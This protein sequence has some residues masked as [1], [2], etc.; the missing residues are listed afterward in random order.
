[1]YRFIFDLILLP[2]EFVCLWVTSVSEINLSSSIFIPETK[3]PEVIPV[4][5]KIESPLIISFKSYFCEIF[6]SH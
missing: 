3:S 6:N 2:F 5:Q 4:A 1:M